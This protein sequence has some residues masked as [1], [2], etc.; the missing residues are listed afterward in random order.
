[1]HTYYLLLIAILL[2]IILACIYFKLRIVSRDVK[3]LRVVVDHQKDYTFLVNDDFVV[4]ETN[5]YASHPHKTENEPTVL[6]NVLHCK[7]AIEAGQ[8]GEADDCRKCPLRFV[9][10]KAFEHEKSFSGLEACMEVYDQQ[11]KPVDM[12]VQVDG[13][14]VKIDRK[15]H[16]V[17][18]VRDVSELQKVG[19]PKIL[20]I[21]EDPA[22]YDKVRLA[23]SD[24]FRVLCA[25]NQHQAFHR[26]MLASS[27][28]FYA[29][30]TDMKFYQ[31]NLDVAK[32]LAKNN[33]VPLFVFASSESVGDVSDVR[34]LDKSLDNQQLLH[35]M[36]SISSSSSCE[37]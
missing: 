29:V 25:D 9:I 21:S 17:V 20:F 10:G 30:I 19:A 31:S 6:G 1:M 36:L 14:Y 11:Q 7:N 8:C 26:L 32:I 23:L 12:D 33:Q 22:L 24:K 16:M 3:Q 15:K 34:I 2:F 37:S 27:Y 13:R 28:K 18:N 4:K 5:Y 35:Q